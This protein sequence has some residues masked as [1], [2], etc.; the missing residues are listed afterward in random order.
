V[1]V[2][3]AEGGSFLNRM[4]ERS[5]VEP[6]RHLRTPA[7]QSV[8]LTDENIKV[9]S[10]DKKKKSTLVGVEKRK[11]PRILGNNNIIRE[12]EILR[13]IEG[14]VKFNRNAK[15]QQQPGANP[16]TYLTI[17]PMKSLRQ[18]DRVNLAIKGIDKITG[19]IRPS[20]LPRPNAPLHSCDNRLISYDSPSPYSNPTP[21]P[22]HEST[23]LGS[24][25]TRNYR[26]K[27]ERNSIHKS[28][29]AASKTRPEISTNPQP[30]H[31]TRRPDQPLYKN[32]IRNK[33]R[34]SNTNAVK[35]LSKVQNT[36]RNADKSI[37]MVRKDRD[38]M[39]YGGNFFG[40]S[41]YKESLIGNLVGKRGCDLGE[42]RSG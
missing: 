39:G 20:D 35:D 32:M 41:E 27:K 24:C 38:G 10:R 17:G 33:R 18:S 6:G 9:K 1:S 8:N 36:G 31:L 23:D 34:N 14:I 5:F 25:D 15:Q 26:I 13:K 2:D 4:A 16:P 19:N 22:Y 30:S 21:Q 28:F 29:D 11:A 12:N 37:K 42:R 40:G 7:V 3:L